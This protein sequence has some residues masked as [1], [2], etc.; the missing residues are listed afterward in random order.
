V[1]TEFLRGALRLALLIFLVALAMLP[2]QP[3]GSGEF[4]VTVLALVV[5]GLFVLA[6]VVLVRWSAPR[7]P[8][9]GDNPMAKALNGRSRTS[10]E[11]REP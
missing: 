10:G 4:V 8:V 6:V 7:V 11:E 1:P 3:R 9:A 2:F 5:G